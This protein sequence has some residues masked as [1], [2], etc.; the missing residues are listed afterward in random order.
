MCGTI[1]L[2]VVL[3]WCFGDTG[4]LVCGVAGAVLVPLLLPIA[5]RSSFEPTRDG[6]AEPETDIYFTQKQIKKIVI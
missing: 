5:L 3:W 1:T 2:D 6:G 4:G